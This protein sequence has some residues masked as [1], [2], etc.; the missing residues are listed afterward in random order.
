M[1][2]ITLQIIDLAHDHRTNDVQIGQGLELQIVAEYTQQQQREFTHMG[3]PPLPD[4]RA[5]S[6]VA[7]TV[8]KQNYVQ[9]LDAR[10]CPTDVTV[11]PGLERQ[12]SDTRNVLKA[13]FHAFKF[14]GTSMVNFDVRIHFCANRCPDENCVSINN[15]PSSWYPIT[16]DPTSSSSSRRRRR[17]AAPQ[18]LQQ[19]RVQN[20][21]YISTVMDV[22]NLPEDKANTTNS[23]LAEEEEENSEAI[24]LNFNLHVRGPDNTNGNS[25]IYGERGVLLIAA[26]GRYK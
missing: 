13:R 25:F 2:K 12:R 23:T 26:V 3:L 21:V 10:G 22:V 19:F 14:A 9:L 6:L 17:Q 4:F 18:E 7:K 16:M 5:T 11:F 8:D 1:P 24:P 20:P 15:S